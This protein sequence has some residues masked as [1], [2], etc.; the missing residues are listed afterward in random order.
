MLLVRKNSASLELVY[1]LPLKRF[2]LTLIV[3]TLNVVYSIVI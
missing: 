3:G 2:Y 1:V